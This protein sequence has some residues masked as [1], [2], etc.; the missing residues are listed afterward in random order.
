MS[1]NTSIRILQVGLSANSGGIE[2]F[3]VNYQM[4]LRPYNVVFDYVSM[5]D[6]LAYEDVIQKAGGCIY[7]LPN[8]KRH[9]IRFARAFYCLVKKY[10]VV[11]I[12]MLSDANILPVIVSRLAKNKKTIIHS[13]NT[14]TEGR[15]RH[16]LHTINKPIVSQLN[17]TRLACGHEAAKWLYTDSV[18]QQAGYE[19]LHNAVNLQKYS[20]HEVT[21]N[22]IRS[23]LCVAED[24]V[25]L[26]VVGRLSRE[27]NLLFML[28]V[29]AKI[30]PNS[31]RVV[32]VH[33]G[34]VTDTRYEQL[35]RN[36]IV[37][38]HLEPYVKLLGCK[39]NVEQYYSAMDVYCMPSLYEG[40]SFTAIEAQVS[41]VRC[42][43]SDTM[44]LETK[45]TE[46]VKFLPLNQDV[47]SN[48][49]LTCRHD[50]HQK[51]NLENLGI[52]GGN[53]DIKA[54]A[55]EL[56]RIYEVEDV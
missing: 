34:P 3:A 9:P 25:L 13:H 17:L 45:I 56:M 53:Y 11:H 50:N 33:V 15:I 24:T 46:N 38:M 10:D 28:G 32:L 44:S 21:R 39:D 41:G 26:G 18:V 29:M 22:K 27:K 20:F 23:E 7:R 12:N 16:I 37:E 40:L 5:D 19:V 2:S 1:R 54:Q 49:L 8:V 35:V 47:W 55:R 31:K 4:A 48:V 6:Y 36:K 42:L 30:V 14:D 43:F 51:R 52:I